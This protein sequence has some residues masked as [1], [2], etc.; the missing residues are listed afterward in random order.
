MTYES[1][2][3]A[4]SPTFLWMLNETSGTDAADA[5]G[6]GHDGTY[7]GSYTQG[8]PGPSGV[9]ANAAG[10]DGS[11]AFISGPWR[12]TSPDV[13]SIELWFKTS[14]AGGP[15]GGFS[16]GASLGNGNG[17]PT[18]VRHH[19]RETGLLHLQLGRLHRPARPGTVNDG[20]WHYAVATLDGSGNLKVYLDGS[21]ASQG[22]YTSLANYN[23]HWLAGGDTGGNTGGG[24]SAGSTNGIAGD[25]SA[26]AVYPVALTSTQVA[27]H[28]AAA[29]GGSTPS[30]TVPVLM[31][32][33]TRVIA[34]STGRIIRR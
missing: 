22:G 24:A 12:G 6:N 4:D 30:G 16:A 34:R 33:R 15:L 10:F 32:A 20:N 14:A 5:T 11:T 21:L 3:L 31:T 2:V 25:L 26:F 8:N 28:Y 17:D 7:T 29:T 18:A 19:D 1:A 23:G 9:T 13:L 27:A